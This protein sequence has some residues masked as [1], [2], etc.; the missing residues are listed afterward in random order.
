MMMTDSLPEFSNEA[1]EVACPN[2]IGHLSLATNYKLHHCSPAELLQFGG[3]CRLCFEKFKKHNSSTLAGKAEPPVDMDE[4]HAHSFMQQDHVA[5]TDDGRIESVTDFEFEK[6]D[7]WGGSQA[8]ADIGEMKENVRHE[9]AHALSLI[10]AWSFEGGL[11]MAYRRWLILV[12]GIRP[13]L[14][15]GLTYAEI[16]APLGLT[17]QALSKSA[18]KVQASLGFKFSR[19]RSDD[20]RLRMSTA[21]QGH[22]RWDTTKKSK[23]PIAAAPPSKGIF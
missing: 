21:M 3:V 22:R 8:E 4:K 10:L 6:I 12:A 9:V 5:F 19:S 7:G 1:G 14:L 23:R 18:L 17:K 2:S 16:G 13:D 20:G 11:K 15:G